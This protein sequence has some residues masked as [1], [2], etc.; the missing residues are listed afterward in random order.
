LVQSQARV[1]R[2]VRARL[3]SSGGRGAFLERGQYLQTRGFKVFEQSD[4]TVVQLP[5]DLERRAAKRPRPRLR[6]VPSPR[7]AFQGSRG[8]N[9]YGL[10]FALDVNF[11][12]SA[13]H[14]DCSRHTPLCCR[15]ST[16]LP[17]AAA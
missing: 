11:L 15:R 10:P 9:P 14:G 1:R 17:T 13:Q 2:T 12:R 5:A 16:T 7:F 3:D 4:V 8:R 6:C